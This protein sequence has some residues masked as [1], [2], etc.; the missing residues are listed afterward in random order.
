MSIQFPQTPGF[1]GVNKPMRMEIDLF[2]LEVEGVIPEAINGAMYRCGPDPQLPPRLGDDIFINGDGQVSGFY[3]SDGHVDF[4]LRYVRTEKFELER[5]ARKALFGAY[6]NPF[7][8]DPSVAGRDR[9]T[10]NTALMWNGGRLYALKEDGRPYEVNPMTLE[11]I[12]R[13]DFGGA[14]A[15]RTFTAHVKY[16]PETHDVIWHGYAADGEATNAIAYGTIAPDGTLVSEQRFTAPYASMIHDFAFTENYILFP[17]M[18]VTS[19]PERLAA[20]G[21]HWAWDGT[22]PTY[23]GIVP[24]NGA[25]EDIRYF[26]GPARWSFHTLNAF[27]EGDRIHLDLTVSERVGFPD[28]P[29]LDG[30]PFDP[31]K[32]R[33]LLTRWTFDMSSNDE[34]FS[35]TVLWDHPADFFEMDPRVAGRPYRHGFMAAKEKDMVFNMIG[36]IDHATGETR[37]YHAGAGASVQEPVFVPR[38]AEAPEGDGYLL[39]VVNHRAE[40]RAEVVILDTDDITAGPVARVHVPMPLR[41]T[42]HSEFVPQAELETAAAL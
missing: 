4:R 22:K 24:R 3:F 39:A 30:S 16:D 5:A 1:T 42:F 25:P 15:S 12:G 6:R 11:T 2:E 29:I 13:N 38:S 40:N 14:M 10:A 20:G 32:G 31:D 34:G 41:M 9:T 28:I 36:H 17:I 21:S 35:E 8:D 37:A 23:V 7:T 33:S 19:D 26:K 18:P 27:E